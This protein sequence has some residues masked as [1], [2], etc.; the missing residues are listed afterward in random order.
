MAL[1]ASGPDERQ[2]ATA[3]LSEAGAAKRASEGRALGY[4]QDGTP[5]CVAATSARTSDV[6]AAY[7]R[8]TAQGTSQ[9]YSTAAGT[10][11]LPP[12]GGSWRSAAEEVKGEAAALPHS[13]APADLVACPGGLHAVAIAAEALCVVAEALCHMLNP[14]ST[15][16]LPDVWWRSA[17]RYEPSQQHGA[18]RGRRGA[19]AAAHRRGAASEKPPA[20]TD[21]ATGRRAAAAGPYPAESTFPPYINFRR[22]PSYRPP[23]PG[24]RRPPPQSRYALG[25]WS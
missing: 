1:V 10:S 24:A 12:A 16:M 6:R 19:A 25:G 7:G 5:G 22:S 4:R 23:A 17:S 11:S 21:P 15:D 18:E 8:C 14:H 3:M 20:P 2:G 13:L 9:L